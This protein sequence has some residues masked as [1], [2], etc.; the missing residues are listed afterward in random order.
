LIA[1]VLL[2]GGPFDGTRVQVEPGHSYLRGGDP[3]PNGQV[4]HYRPTKD[5][6]PEGRPVIY[7]FRCLDHVVT[8]TPRGNVREMT[9]LDKR[10]VE[11]E[12]PEVIPEPAPAA[13][14]F[15]RP[16]PVV[17]GDSNRGLMHLDGDTEARP[18][19]V[20][21]E[22]H[23]VTRAGEF[24]LDREKLT[25]RLREAR[26]AL[27]LHDR[28]ARVTQTIGTIQ[29]QQAQQPRETDA[30]GATVSDGIGPRGGRHCDLAYFD[31]HEVD[32]WLLQI[33]ALIERAE[34]AID[35]HRGLLHRNYQAMSPEDKDKLIRG[36]KLRGL[37]HEQVSA[38]YPE[39]GRPATILRK[40]R[41]ADQDA[42]GNPKVE[43]EQAA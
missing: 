15:G 3:V 43:R 14:K 23:A 31:P 20:W 2:E 16:L 27:E 11:Y 4:A 19:A 38:V 26:E 25:R 21:E 41:E 9:H 22:T 6:S 13:D 12:P 30:K 40:R 8:A 10:R 37:D 24:K 42:Y 7:R 28:L 36:P 17:D 34:E 32:G 29:T 35:V 39:L 33:R 5:R 18:P 1:D